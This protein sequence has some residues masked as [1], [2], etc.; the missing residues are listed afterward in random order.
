MSPCPLSVY[1]GLLRPLASWCL[2][3][4]GEGPPMLVGVVLDAANV[5]F[6]PVELG[7]DDP[8]DDLADLAAPEP[9]DVL[10]VIAATADVDAHMRRGTVAHA[11]DRHGG[12]ATEL[13]EWCGRRRSLRARGGRLHDAC[14][15]LF[16]PPL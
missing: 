5:R 1:S 8:L 15:E 14:L 9:W 12:S 6:Q 3:T 13:D 16:G 7:E 2:D 4:F 10:V 11:V